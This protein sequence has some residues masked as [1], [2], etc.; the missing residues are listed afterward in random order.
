MHVFENTRALLLRT[1][2]IAMLGAGAVACGSGE[3]QAADTA[4]AAP[5]L[6]YLRRPFTD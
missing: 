2:S 3:Q 1:T 6:R 4:A 5:V